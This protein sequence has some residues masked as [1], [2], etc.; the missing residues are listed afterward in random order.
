MAIARNAARNPAPSIMTPANTGPR[1]L[2]KAKPI[3]N[4]ENAFRSASEVLTMRA[5]WR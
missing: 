4:H 1:T 3:A 5:V 2:D